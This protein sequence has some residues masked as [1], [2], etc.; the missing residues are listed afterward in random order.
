MS[1][2]KYRVH[3]WKSNWC[4]G[5]RNWIM[6][7][8]PDGGRIVRRFNTPSAFSTHAEALAAGLDWAH[9]LNNRELEEA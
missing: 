2:P 9:E 5:G 3:V 4:S 1:R 6:G 7:V 8:W